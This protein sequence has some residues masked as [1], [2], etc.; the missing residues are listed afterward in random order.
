MSLPVDDRPIHLTSKI[1]AG[2]PN[3]A[4]PSFSIDACLPN[5]TMQATTG[6][7]A[8][9]CDGPS[10][11]KSFSDILQSIGIGLVLIPLY[12]F[13]QSIAIAKSFG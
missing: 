11:T 6:G 4:I 10:V 9:M 1:P 7:N 8:I 3:I 5:T 13:L 12:S 2:L